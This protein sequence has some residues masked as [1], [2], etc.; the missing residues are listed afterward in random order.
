MRS[1]VPASTTSLPCFFT[2]M[3]H[4]SKKEIK[5]EPKNLTWL[6]SITNPAGLLSEYEDAIRNG[7]RRGAAA[8]LIENRSQIEPPLGLPEDGREADCA[9]SSWQRGG[10]RRSRRS[11]RR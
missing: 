4:L 8:R 3:W 11:A 1:D 6:K 7:K 2:S 10:N 5:T 9:A